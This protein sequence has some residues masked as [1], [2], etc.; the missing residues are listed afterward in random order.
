M[1]G[2]FEG[3]RIWWYWFLQGHRLWASYNHL[4]RVVQW[5]V[6]FILQLKFHWLNRPLSYNFICSQDCWEMK[7]YEVVVVWKSSQEKTWKCTCPLLEQGWAAA[8]YTLGKVCLAEISS[9]RVVD[10]LCNS[11]RPFNVGE[12]I[13]NFL[14]CWFP[15]YNR[16]GF[17]C[18]W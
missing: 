1:P 3:H 18:L 17:A 14:R 12:F 7:F 5:F 8:K 15:M 4:H 6:N 11:G 16:Q 13:L 10:F 2:K 9:P